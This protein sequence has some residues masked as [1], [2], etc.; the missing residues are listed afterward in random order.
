LVSKEAAS[1]MADTHEVSKMWSKKGTYIT[2]EEDN[3]KQVIDQ[4][5][6]GYK[7]ELVMVLLKEIENELKV[8]ENNNDNQEKIKELLDRYMAYTQ[9]K[10][11]ISKSLGERIILK[12]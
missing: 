9:F 7:Y 10:I 4:A 6:S 5:I 11:E 3:L 12:R 2:T 8:T 1:L